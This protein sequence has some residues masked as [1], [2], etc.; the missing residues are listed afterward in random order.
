MMNRFAFV[1][2][3]VAA[4]PIR[5]QTSLQD[6]PRPITLAEA[7]TLAQRNAPAAVQARG[8]IRQSVADRGVAVAAFIPSVNLQTWASNTRGTR[9]SERNELFRIQGPPWNY[10]TQIGANIE[11]FD[12]GRRFYELRRARASVDAA[13]SNEVLQRFNVALGV[14]QQY[15]AVLAAHESQAAARAQLEQAQQQFRVAAARVAAG[16]AT[17]SDSLR[18]VI[19]V[20]NAQLALLTAENNLRVANAALTRLVATPFTVTASPAD[21]FES[22]GLAVDSTELARLAGR[23]P[24]IRQAESQNVVARAGL[25]AARTAYLPNVSLNY[26]RSGSSTDSSF[27]FVDDVYGYSS[28]FRI[29]ASYPLFNQL[30]REQARVRAGVN[31]DDAEA[32]LRD[33]RLRAQQELAQYLGLIRTAE[34]RVAIQQASVD[35]A[36]ED[37]RVQQQRYSLG[38]STLLDVLTSQTQLNQARA[39]LIQA[40][41]D[42]RIAKAQL[43]A[44]VGRDL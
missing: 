25:R 8:Q 13:E 21:T 18:S 40:R 31:L 22:R 12:G 19:Q 38:A 11:L 24:M 42:R 39:A 3:C 6:S 26:G 37:L 28:S 16:A 29:T 27:R 33:A 20:G 9:L 34:Q 23:S 5:A 32:S 4:L 30:Q 41:Y 43:E 7:V 36:D 10:G 14:K 35:A 2:A 15:Y 1:A 44:L 17:R